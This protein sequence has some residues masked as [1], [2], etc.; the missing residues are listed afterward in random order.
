CERGRLVGYLPSRLQL[1]DGTVFETIA[2]FTDAPPEQV[3]EA[4]AAAGVHEAV[5]RLAEGYST[6]IGP[7]SSL[8]SGGQKQRLALARALF[9]GPRLLVLDEPDASLDHDG[10]TALVEALR[11]ALAAGMV[12]VAVSH[13]PALA[14]LADQ[15]LRIEDGRVASLARGGRDR[16][17][18]AG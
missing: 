7:H 16:L 1:L 2:R 8:L 14:Q 17:S 10:E 9:G 13:R 3:V 12:V 5:G 11:R 15:V 4:A 18:A 6:R